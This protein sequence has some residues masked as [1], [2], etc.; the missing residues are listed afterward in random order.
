MTRGESNKQFN[1]DTKKKLTELKKEAARR[2]M[3]SAIFTLNEINLAITK[4]KIRKSASL[5]EIFPEF[6][7]Y[8]W[9]HTTAL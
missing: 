4:L 8:F 2:G 3:I 1:T 7:I 9:L 5:D 6:F